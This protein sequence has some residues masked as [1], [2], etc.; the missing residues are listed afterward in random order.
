MPCHA[1]AAHQWYMPDQ[2]LICIPEDIDAT[3][4]VV[5]KILPTGS[6]TAQQTLS[7][8][9]NY[10]LVVQIQLLQQTLPVT[11]FQPLAATVLYCTVVHDPWCLHSH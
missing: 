8:H 1:E 7:L 2:A 4:A 5:C 9:L 3:G 11:R 6:G 10:F